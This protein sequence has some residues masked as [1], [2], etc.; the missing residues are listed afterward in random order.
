MSRFKPH[1]ALL[2]CNIVWAMDYPFY[3]IVL[4]HYV[5]PMAMVAGSLVVTALF[6][7]VPLLWQKAERVARADIRKLIGA[8]L[9]IGV[10]RKVFIM[11]GLSMT[12]PIDGSIIDT[13]VPLLVLLLSVLLGMDRFTE[14]KVAGLLLGMAGAVAV[15]LTGASSSH[16]HSHVWGNVMIMLCA[17]ATA[18][19][20]VWF[21][22]LVARYRI[23]TVLRWV[24]CVAAVVALP[25]G[26]KE[27][28]HTDYAAIAGHALFPTLFVLTVPTYLPNL[29]LNYA[30]K[31]VP[32]TV[33]SIYTY[34]QP[35]LAIAI[36]VGMGL[37]KLHADTV[38]FA[39][40]IFVGV[41]L[42][43]RSYSV[44]PRHPAP[45]AAPPHCPG[46]GNPAGSNSPECG[47]AGHAACPSPNSGETNIGTEYCLNAKRRA[48][49]SPFLW[50]DELQGGTLAASCGL[51]CGGNREF[52]DGLDLLV[53]F[54]GRFVLA[55]GLDALYGDQLAVE[56]DAFGSQCLGQVGGGNRT[57]ELALLGLQGQR[58]RQ[59]G[60]GLGECL[61]VGKD[62]GILVGALAEVLGEH[63][64][65]GCGGSLCVTL[66]NQV[67]VR[68]T[69][70][71]GHDVVGVAQVF[72]VF[73]QNN[74]HCLF[75]L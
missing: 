27:I 10:L 25:F 74:F 30:L 37:D 44:P 70:L 71:Y 34:L 17:C 41:G 35:V 59:V 7:L 20:M 38:V 14:L 60:D 39:L 48:F 63:L 54:G 36:S 68:I 62:L 75:L 11:Y 4:P 24:Y 23:T 19:Y 69:G 67:V 3:N 52:D 50:C 6:S 12:S 31:S 13:I 61:C 28:I 46:A 53:E 45:P 57:E 33:S 26:L 18:L 65:G 8:A 58:E 40:V 51:F 47:L 49:G 66:G 16:Q 64:L 2:I 22:A 32:A 43:L 15:V 29:M 21:K 73:D 1:I 9:L 55:D 72:H 56:F 5:H 42:V